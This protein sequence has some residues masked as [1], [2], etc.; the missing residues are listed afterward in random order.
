MLAT[1]TN[2]TMQMLIHF[3]AIS[4][5]TFTTNL[6]GPD[7]SVPCVHSQRRYLVRAPSK[8]QRCTASSKATRILQPF[9]VDVTLEPQSTGCI[10]SLS[11]QKISANS[12]VDQGCPL[13]TCGFSA[14]IDPVLRFVLADIC[15]QLDS[16]ARLFADWYLW[17]EPQCLMD[18]ITLMVAATKSVQPF[19]IQV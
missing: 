19:K 6:P 4:R 10:T 5:P 1:M 13:S 11:T 7:C 16:G 14:A 2:S 12:G 9:F 17:I 3:L 15:T 18:T 8:H